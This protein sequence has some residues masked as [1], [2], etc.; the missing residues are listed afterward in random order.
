MKVI[1]NILLSII[2]VLHFL[3][4][5]A[6]ENSA[7][8]S[9]IDFAALNFAD[10]ILPTTSFDDLIHIIDKYDS[11]SFKKLSIVAG[12]YYN[13]FDYDITKFYNQNQAQQQNYY[14]IYKNK[15]GICKD[16][17]LLFAAIC[18]KLNIVNE[19]IEGYTPQYESENK[20]YFETNHV[21]NVVNING[22]WYHC[23]LLGFCGYVFFNDSTEKIEFVKQKKYSNF[24]TQHPSFII[25][26]IPADPIWQLS[27]YPIPIDSIETTKIYYESSLQSIQKPNFYKQIDDY[28]KLPAIEKSLKFADNAYRYNPNNHNIIAVNYYNAAVTIFNNYPNNKSK[29]KFALAYLEKSKTH[30]DNCIRINNILKPQILMA[31]DVIT[32]KINTIK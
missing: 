13:N 2:F 5:K 24:L 19:I 17:T 14:D 21:W 10:S 29:L 3:T 27:D 28:I 1:L 25:K 11:S 15:N 16:Y 22:Q 4:A 23:D 31:I 7:Y 20:N 26:H 8:V 12:W 30:I 18:N 6:Q 32:K 9:F